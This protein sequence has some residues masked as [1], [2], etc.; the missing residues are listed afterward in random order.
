M[1]L[2]LCSQLQR[3]GRNDKRGQST[4]QRRSSCRSRKH[5]CGGSLRQRIA[6]GFQG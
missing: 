6:H 4:R 5:S 1:R 3:Q 2:N